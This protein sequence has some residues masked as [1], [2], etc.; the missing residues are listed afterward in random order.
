VRA[1]MTTP[2]MAGSARLGEVEDPT[3]SDGEVLVD[4]LCVG[5]DGTDEEIAR[6]E[7]GESPEGD[8]YLIIGHESIGRVVTAGDGLAE[9]TLVAA[10]VRRPDPVP[11]VNCGRDEW[12]MCLNGQYTE[13]GIKARHGYLA[14]RYSERPKFLVPVP[15]ELGTLGVLTEPTSIAEK[16]VDQA[17]RVQHGRLAWEPARA[18]VTG[19]GAIGLLAALV[20]RL[21]GLEVF[22]YDQATSGPKVE[23]AEAMGARYLPAENAELGAALARQVGRIDVAIEAT[24]YSPLSFQLLETIGNNGVAVLTGVSGGQRH[25]E[26]PVD[27][28]NL[29]MVLGNKVAVGSVNANRGHFKAAVADLTEAHARW[30]GLLERMITRREPLE[31]FEAALERGGDE[32]KV[33]VDVAKGT[34]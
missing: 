1:V 9:G 10:I 32:V 17:W 34:S 25:A 16:A 8:D 19:A 3:P 23:L 30:P 24:G 13:R 21:R 29:D 11:C 5:V 31:R 22:V 28:L 7:Y 20:L 26:L 6:G 4:V 14:E 2:G 12:D 18:V 15:D 27:R 33:V